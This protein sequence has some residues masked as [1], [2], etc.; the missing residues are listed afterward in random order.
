MQRGAPPVPR[1]RFAPTRVPCTLEREVAVL[2][3]RLLL[4][5]AIIAAILVLSGC[6]SAPDA[7]I[8]EAD[9]AFHDT[10]GEEH[11]DALRRGVILHYDRDHPQGRPLTAEERVRRERLHRAWDAFV[12]EARRR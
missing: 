9:L 3:R 7:A 12:D 6:R 1:D 11:R 10:I 5:L 2:K 4:V 8:L